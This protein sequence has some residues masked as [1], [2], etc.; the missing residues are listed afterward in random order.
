MAPR[1]DLVN[2]AVSFLRDPSVASSPLDKRI[3]FL[4]S[5]NLTQEEI[6]VSLAR[7]GDETPA[8]T[9]PPNAPYY[10]PPQQQ[11]MYRQPAGN[12]N[13]NQYGNWQLS[14]EGQVMVSGS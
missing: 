1:E 9:Q 11:G 7:A 3:A 2:S 6:D 13:Y 12:Y 10:P 8:A 14:L 5:K 4:Q